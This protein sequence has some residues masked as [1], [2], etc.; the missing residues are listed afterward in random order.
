VTNY[1]DA[2][3]KRG[4]LRSRGHLVSDFL[5][6]NS[7]PL[8]YLNSIDGA[9]YDGFNLLVAD[10]SELAYLSN[11]GDEAQLLSP[12]VYAL[13]NARLDSPCAKVQRSKERLA[14]LLAEDRINTTEL[15][16]LLSDRNKG[17]LEEVDDGRL[18]FA[19]AHAITAPFIVL[20]EF[21]TRCSTIV[22]ANRDGEWHFLERRFDPGGDNTGESVLSFSDSEH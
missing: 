14:Q 16:R 18:P 9:A 5:Q 7:S 3:P 6:S 15:L 21:G 8:D 20:P 1:R 19:T 10:G 12:G 22:T 17:P 4:K 2:E 13:S 11:Q